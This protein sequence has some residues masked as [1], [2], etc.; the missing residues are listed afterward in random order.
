MEVQVEGADEFARASYAKICQDTFRDLGV[1]TSIDHTYLYL[2]PLEHRFLISV[3]IGRVAS[4]LKVRDVTQAERDKLKISDEK[5][6]PKLLAVLWDSYGA[7]VQQ[8]GRLEI[9]LKLDEKEFEVVKELV[10]YDPREDLIA[11][12]LDGIDRILP[13]GARVRYP[14]PSPSRVT[15]LASEDPIPEEWKRRAEEM[16]RALENHV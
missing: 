6:A 7:R 9:G 13:E 2:N 10:V 15:I 3:K 12:I 11:R 16:V 4:P 5:Y 14:L 1:R 8:V